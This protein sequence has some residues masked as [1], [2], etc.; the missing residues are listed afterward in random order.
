M[1][2][3][4]SL[5]GRPRRDRHPAT[6]PLPLPAEIFLAFRSEIPLSDIRTHV[7]FYKTHPR[8][9]A[10]YDA[11]EKSEV[12]WRL[13]CWH[14]GI[15]ALC[16]DSPMFP[17][18]WRKIAM[19]VVEKDGFCKHPQCGEGLL[20]YN[21]QRMEHAEKHV[22]PPSVYTFSK[23][24][25]GSTTVANGGSRPEQLAVHHALSHITFS[26]HRSS[27]YTRAGQDALLR[28]AAH[29]ESAYDGSVVL[30]DHPLIQRSFAT[31]VPVSGLS[32]LRLAGDDPVEATGI[33]RPSGIAVLDVV[34]PIHP[35]E[36][37]PGAMVRLL[38]SIFENL[39]EA[40]PGTI[41]AEQQ[42]SIRGLLR[43]SHL[44]EYQFEGTVLDGTFPQFSVRLERN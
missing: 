13:V 43:I 27:P 1:S 12:F 38:T 15:T 19:E 30:A 18:F 21:R 42:R 25:A 23:P 4:T 34:G 3:R 29:E 39:D 11:E 22:Q 20:E 37:S 8:I 32:L 2:L 44:G 7:C 31:D 36:L 26:R 14:S 5:A 33:G 35:E 24:K 40:W 10:L 28:S 17:P 16:T 6:G 9:A 41:P